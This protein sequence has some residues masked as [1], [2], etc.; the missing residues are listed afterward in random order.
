MLH[1]LFKYFHPPF[2]LDIMGLLGHKALRLNLYGKQTMPKSADIVNIADATDEERPDYFVRKDGLTFAGTHLIVDLWDGEGFNDQSLIE[3]TLRDCIEIS[4]ATLL[5]FH[6]HQF[7]PDGISGVA[8][9]AESHISFHSWPERGFMAL[10]I[11]MCGNTDPYKA[12]PVLKAAF[13]PQKVQ[14]NDLKRGLIG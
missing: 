3:A 9:L 13:K 6:M 14:L 11:F 7:E 2:L 8:V 12:I 5:H 10:D 1:I 4:G